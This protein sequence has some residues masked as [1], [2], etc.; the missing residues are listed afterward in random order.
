M[1]SAVAH[2]LG[3][4]RPVTEGPAATRGDATGAGA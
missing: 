1:N 3:E 2:T 4:P